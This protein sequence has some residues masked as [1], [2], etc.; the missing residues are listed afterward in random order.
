MAGVL[1]G[2]FFQSRADNV[3]QDAD[4]RFI[5]NPTSRTVWFD[6]DGSGAQ[7]PVL[8]AT[9]QALADFTA[10]DVLVIA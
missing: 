4:D 7:G 1:S 2:A 10:A 5:F 9:L 3:A 6:A 8:V